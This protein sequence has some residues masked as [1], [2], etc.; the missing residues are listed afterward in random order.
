MSLISVAIYDRECSGRTE[1]TGRFLENMRDTVDWTRHRIF[2]IDNNSCQ[3]T[4]EVIAWFLKYEGIDCTVITNT[5]NV[6]TAKA[7]NQGWAYRRPGEFCLKVDNDIEIHQQG[8]IEEME[9]VIKRD[10]SI[11]VVGLKRKDCEERADHPE[12]NLRSTLM[13]LPHKPGQNWI[14]VERAHHVMGTCHL[15]NPALIDKIGGYFQVGVYG[16]DD[17]LYCLRA[18]LAEFK[19]VFLP[20]IDLDHLYEVDLVGAST[21]YALWK[22]KHAGDNIEDYVKVVREYESGQR[23]LKVEL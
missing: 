2:L 3:Q 23:P 20:H 16:W 22:Q 14:I 18:H 10:P 21:D 8:W 19:T 9:D 5:E 17:C 4:K 11:G 15:V 1:V 13:Q 12:H 6:G 7:I